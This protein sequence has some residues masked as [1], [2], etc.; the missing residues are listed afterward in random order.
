MNRHQFLAE[1]HRILNPRGYVEIGVQTGASLRLASCPALG[2]DPNPV[3]AY[4]L[5]STTVI[6][7]ETSDEFF[8]RTRSAQWMSGLPQPV[9]LAFIDGLHL[10]E[11]ALRDFYHV[12]GWVNTM[13]RKRPG[14]IVFDDVLPRNQE[15][16]GRMP[17]P[18]DW[19]GDVWKVPDVLATEYP[20]R[21]QIL[22]D[23][24]PTGVLLVEVKATTLRS[25]GTSWMPNGP[26]GGDY[27]SSH[28][29]EVPAEVLA[30]THAVAPEVA[31]AA[32][33]G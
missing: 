2:I 21:R 30:R 29:D 23:V 10:H 11:Q 27:R 17:L 33:A 12:E 4:P 1:L 19:T 31:L 14:W 18:G 8:A 24:E 20:Y 28:P 3:V 5:P 9:D 6:V 16:A 26:F 25:W 22:V 32:V 13:S 7:A 15:E